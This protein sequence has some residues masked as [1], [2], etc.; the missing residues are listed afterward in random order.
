MVMIVRLLQ[1]L[2]PRSKPMPPPSRVQRCINRGYATMEDLIEMGPEEIADLAR[3]FS[4]EGY[5]GRAVR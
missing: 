4:G 2:W 5:D 3:A 1:Q